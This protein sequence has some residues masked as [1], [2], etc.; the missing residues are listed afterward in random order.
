MMITI[1]GDVNIMFLIKRAT[2]LIRTSM[3]ISKG[4][5]NIE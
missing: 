1:K 2:R 3:T 4:D 5:V